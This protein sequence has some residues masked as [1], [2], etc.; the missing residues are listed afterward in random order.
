MRIN[1][2]LCS[3]FATALLMAPSMLLTASETA[4]VEKKTALSE[5]LTERP[6]LR[7]F[8]HPLNRE[9]LDVGH[10]HPLGL[11]QQIPQVLIPP[12]A[13]DQHTDVPVHR[14]HDS[15]AHLRPAVVHNAFDVFE[16]HVG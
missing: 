14:F 15:E 6:L 1:C 13:V 9:E 10:C 16:Q 12:A 5:N 11:Q 8:L 7:N 2:R 3:L 4:L